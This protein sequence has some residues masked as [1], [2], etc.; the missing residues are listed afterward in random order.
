MCRTVSSRCHNGALQ[1]HLIMIISASALV[2]DASQAVTQDISKIR[3]N[4]YF[5]VAKH[6]PVVVNHL[7]CIDYCMLRHLHFFVCVNVK[8]GPFL[9]PLTKLCRSL[10][11][12]SDRIGPIVARNLPRVCSCLHGQ[13][14][15][16]CSPSCSLGRGHSSS[17]QQ[18]FSI[19][20][21]RRGVL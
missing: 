20:S 3:L 6:I 8:H 11:K 13:K 9:S 21:S 19:T 4:L 10:T 18:G 7:I 12:Q 15:T 1:V 14:L 2:L 16:C 5:C 17:A